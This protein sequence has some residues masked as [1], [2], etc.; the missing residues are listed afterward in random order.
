MRLS[1]AIIFAIVP[2]DV[3]NMYS[4]PALAAKL[5]VE[6]AVQAAHVKRVKNKLR[7]I[8][9]GLF[10]DQHKLHKENVDVSASSSMEH[11]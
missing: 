11:G 10:D 7:E 1:R 6:K 9:G 5:D 2:C 8:K 4:C 3:N